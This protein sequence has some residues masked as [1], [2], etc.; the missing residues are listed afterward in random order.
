MSDTKSQEMIELPDSAPGA[1]LN[2]RIVSYGDSSARPKIY[3]QAA[4]HADETP[5][6]LVSHELEKLL[7]AADAEGRINGHIVLVPVANP[8]GLGQF[9]FGS[10]LGRYHAI[11]G[12]NFNRNYPDL[13]P[14]LRDALEHEFNQDVEHN[15]ELIRSTCRQML[16]EQKPVSA[17]D[18]MR[19]ALFIRAIDADFVFDLHCDDEAIMHL[20]STPSVWPDIHDLVDFLECP[21][22]LLAENSGGNPFD[23]ACSGIW[24][25]LASAFPGV[26][27]PTNFVA[28]TIELRGQ[29]DVDETLARQDARALCAFMMS[30]GI[31]DGDPT[32][33]PKTDPA[34]HPLQGLMRLKAPATGVVTFQV[35]PGQWVDVGQIIATVYPLGDRAVPVQVE[36]PIAG[37]VYSRRIG[38]YVQAGLKLAVV[39]G[40]EA[41]PTTA[42]QLLLG[43]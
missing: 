19:H 14:L 4:L 38:R 27:I 31:I 35:R 43:D 23:E 5:G 24:T 36:S 7:D 10:L 33:V 26:P 12:I 37:L 8:I 2:L 32:A 1:K 34:V 16:A 40:P 13:F 15:R 29:S 22:V 21:L 28:T 41:L 17:V 18:S 39:S 42:G 11:D 9:N 6:L 30:R 25:Q 3:L 20:Y